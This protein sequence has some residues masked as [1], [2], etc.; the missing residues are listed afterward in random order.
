MLSSE[1]STAST[2]SEET[3][4][5]QRDR[6]LAFSFA[7]SDLLIEIDPQGKVVYA[8]GAIKDLTGHDK[9]IM[10]E[11]WLNFFTPKDAVVL[12]MLQR[13]A[14]AGQRCGPVLVSMK[15]KTARPLIFTGIKMPES[16]NFYIALS[17]GNALMHGIGAQQRQHQE[18]QILTKE[19]FIDVAQ[20]ALKM[21]RTMGKDVSMTMIDFADAEK[22]RESLGEQAW[23]DLNQSI[24]LLL[25]AQSLDGSTAAELAAGRYSIIH[26]SSLSAEAIKEQMIE[27]SKE[28]D[29][30]GKG[31]QVEYKK[32]S[33][34][35]ENLS[36]RDA[37]R[38]LFYTLSEF[39]RKG[40]D[41]T[42]ESLNSSFKTYM[43]SNAQKI[44]EFKEFIDS[45]AF[46]VHFQPIVNLNTL[47][48]THYESLCRF[49]EGNTYEW[50]KFGEDIGMAAEFDIAVCKRAINFIN[51]H[52]KKHEIKFSI[53][54]SGQSIENDDFIEKLKNLLKLNKSMKNRIIFEIT[55]STHIN[56]LDKAANFIQR[57]KSDGYETALDDFGA[58]AASFQYL[59]SL[60]VDYVKIDGKYIRDLLDDRRNMIMVKNLT[61]M[62]LDLGIKVVAEYVETA[63]QVKVL[64]DLGVHYGQ[65][66]YFGKAEPE[67]SYQRLKG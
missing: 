21:A 31:L 58:G 13:Q 39:E 64:R 44:K 37:T 50:V 1:R 46:S 33:T 2:M 22:A 8:V 62:C 17:V 3:I 57:L 56:D 24:G 25:S 35:L 38:A 41:M 42:I 4:K 12:K 34:D 54:I 40:A 30:T 48:A 66:Y 32:V 27:L 47:E 14:R 45:L 43:V 61:Q 11:S 15:N 59:S 52:D 51:M 28:K 36:E 53:N 63:E 10:G 26:D 29:Q 23:N 65:G 55:E 9:K 7:S 67:P 19:T 60:H 6:F 49:K 5:A 18:K 20:D 16:E